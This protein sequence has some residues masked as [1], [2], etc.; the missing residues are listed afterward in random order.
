MP[1]GALPDFVL[2]GGM[3]CGTT[4]LHHYLG[5]HPEIATSDPKE[6]NFFFGDTPGTAGNWWRGVDWYADRFPADARVRGESSPGYTS[7]D[8]P[9]VAARL[10]RVVPDARLLYLRRDPWERAVSQYLHHRRDGDERRPLAEAILDPDSQ[11]VARSRHRERLRPFL[12]RFAPDR[13]LVLEHREL[14]ERRPATL[15]RVFRFLGVDPTFWSDELD[16]R[17]NGA[18]RPHPAVDTG[19]RRRFLEAVAG[20]PRPV[21]AGD[22]PQ[23]VGGDRLVHDGRGGP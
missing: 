4:S 12:D 6:L 15:R 8:H 22:R 11:Y 2:I 3:K 9:Q 21:G 17:W 1:V 7:P 5:C 23:P 10:A 16:V 19:V 18:G 13:I 20:H 14:L